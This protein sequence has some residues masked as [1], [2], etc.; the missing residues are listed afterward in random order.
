MRIAVIYESIYGNT[1][2]IAG[3]VADGLRAHGEVTL[4][5]ADERASTDADLLV[6]GA[7]T[8]A[9]GLPTWMSRR[10]IEEAAEEAEKQGHP[11]ES[12]PTPA[13]RSLL[14]RLQAVG[15]ASAACFDTR[16]DKSP[17]LTGSAAKTIAKKL[18]RLGYELIA[19]PE[20]FFVVDSEGPLKDG[21]LE[22]ARA[23]GGSL[24]RTT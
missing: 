17:L 6:L 1:G 16:F 11:L 20:S 9:H 24:V 2:T 21:E 10:A 19:P 3:A 4:E 15:G 18:G 12:E 8:H 23:W 7:P 13:M 22:R 14:D 5:P